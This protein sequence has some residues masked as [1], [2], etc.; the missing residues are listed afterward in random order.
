MDLRLKLADQRAKS[1]VN[2]F[3]ERPV[4]EIVSSATYFYFM[5]LERTFAERIRATANKA[6]MA[7]YKFLFS[8]K[9]KVIS[10]FDICM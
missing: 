2:S 3:S 6:A 7:V 5:P 9:T 1:V 8:I 10:L 4:V